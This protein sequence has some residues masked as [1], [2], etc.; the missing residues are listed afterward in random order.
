M[1]ITKILGLAVAFVAISAFASKAQKIDLSAST[2]K[3]TGYHLAKSYD[4]YGYIKIKS[5]EVTIKDGKLT[6]G[7]IIIDMNSISNSDLEDAKD[8]S[9]LVKDLKS[10]R[11][12]NVKEFPEASLVLTSIEGTGNGNYA[13]AAEVEIRGLKEKI[14]FN[15]VESEGKSGTTFKGQLQIDR[16]KHDVMYGWSVGNAILSNTIDLEVHIVVPDNEESNASK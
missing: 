7:N 6:A 14:E 10:E 3:W 2:V 11:F 9:K 15:L 5:G 1:K 8:N 16:T 12:F 4:H 13:V